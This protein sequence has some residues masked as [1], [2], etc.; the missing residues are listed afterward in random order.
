MFDRD[1]LISA[2]QCHGKVV[3]VVITRV[4]GSAPRE[5]GAA[6]LV[7]DAG[8][9][10]TIGGGAL[11]FGL[12]QDA[13]LLAADKWSS[14]ALGPDLG[15][16]CG[17][18]VDVLSEV[19]DLQRAQAQPHDVVMRG[20]APMP[21]SIKRI[22]RKMRSEGLLPK[23]HMSEGW[24][25][26][27]VYKPAQ[28]LWIW[29]AGHVG[30][31]LI[32]ILRHLPGFNITWVDTGPERFPTEVDE[33]INVVPASDPNA[34]VRYAPKNAHHLILTYSH[35]LDLELCNHLLHQ[36]FTSC[37][38]IGSKTKWARFKKRLAQLGHDPQTV[39]AITCPI[40]DP[41]M[42]KHPH[43]IALSVSHSM[44]ENNTLQ[45]ANKRS[46]AS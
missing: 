2:S 1:A 13:R 45:I 21:M 22:K 9:S 44:V 5:V 34:L 18:A 6:M 12:A 43:L 10:G 24:F 36:G 38:L 40:G 4:K 19:Y 3:R 25:V 16:C 29:G 37:G 35:V 41:A 11:E 17:G 28:D 23:A 20:P 8:Q 7:W 27:P 26:E 15:Q 30:R 33:R 39:S 32:D 14:H 31:A 42:G 46:A